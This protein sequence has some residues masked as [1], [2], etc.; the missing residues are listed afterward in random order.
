M[1]YKETQ[2]FK[3]CLSHKK[4]QCP[5]FY[6]EVTFLQNILMK[7]SCLIGFLSI[8]RSVGKYCAKVSHFHSLV[9]VSVSHFAFY[10]SSL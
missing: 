10:L 3:H 2:D 9:L 6:T 7:Y 4:T 1:A 5:H 8:S